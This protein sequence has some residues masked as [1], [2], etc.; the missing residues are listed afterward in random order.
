M[1]NTL[2]ESTKLDEVRKLIFGEEIKTYNSEIDAIK[3]SLDNY[4]TEISVK[5]DEVKIE[6]LKSIE[7]LE[8]KM[9]TRVADFQASARQELEMQRRNTVNR[10]A[11]SNIFDEISKSLAQ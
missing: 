8:Q 9:L 6:M 2:N 1:E 11:L 5:I 4:R 7:S 3:R 10:A